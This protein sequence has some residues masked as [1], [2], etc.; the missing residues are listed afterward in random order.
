MK[1]YIVRATAANGQIRAFAAVTTDL[2]NEARKTHDTSPVVSAALGRTLTMAGMMGST[3]KGDKDLIT[4]IIKGDGPMRGLTV[5]ADSHGTVKGYPYVPVVDIPPKPNGKL[6]VSGAIGNGVLTIIRDLG[7]REPYIG[8]LALVTGEIAE[9][10]TYYYMQSEQIPSVIGLGV[11]TNATE[12]I[13]HAGGFMIQLMPDAK[14]ETISYLEQRVPQI[15]SVTEM[16]EKG[17][18]AEG[19]LK[20]I[21]GELEF[22]ITEKTELQYDCNCSKERF[23]EGLITLG[24]KELKAILEEDEK[25]EVLCHFC[26]TP[27]QFEKQE[28]EEMIQ[29]LEKTSNK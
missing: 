21:L 1:N 16:M 12:F 29:S 27:Y 23:R 2:V 14:D 20:F 9:D 19:M 4:I 5:T 25:A 17:Y 10:F 15:P 28:L 7:L 18:D 11:L 8:Q 24:H 22:H 26:N 3:L 13:A 6:D